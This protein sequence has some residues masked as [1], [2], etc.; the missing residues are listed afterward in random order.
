MVSVTWI[1]RTLASPPGPVERPARRMVGPATRTSVHREDGDGQVRRSAFGQVS[2][3]PACRWRQVRRAPS[4]SIESA[5]CGVHPLGHR[6]SRSAVSEEPKAS[7]VGPAPETT[8]GTPSARSAATRRQR[9][10]HRGLAVVLVQP[11]LGR[12]EQV[13]GLPGERGDQQG[14][15]AGVG[16]GVGVRHDV[17]QQA[18]RDRRS[19]P[20]VGGTKHDGRDPRVDPDAG[21]REPVARPRGRRSSKPP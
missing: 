18:A 17:G 6:D 16:G 3:H 4:T 5:W 12:G 19:R 1:L 2:R 21:R 15:A 14:R 10:G 9:L 20:P 7:T 8:A 11:V 13:L